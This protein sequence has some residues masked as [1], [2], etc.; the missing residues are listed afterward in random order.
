MNIFRKEEMN[1]KQVA[2]YRCI[3]CGVE[4]K[5]H[6][7]KKKQSNQIVED[8]ERRLTYV[9]GLNKNGMRLSENHIL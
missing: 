6:K 2:V 8:K 4:H 3:Y 1:N 9:R 5:H 7:T